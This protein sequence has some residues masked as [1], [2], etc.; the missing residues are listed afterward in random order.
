MSNRSAPKAER[1]SSSNLSAELTRTITEAVLSELAE[2]GYGQLSMDGVARRAKAGKSALYRRWPS[3]QE[4][5]LDAVSGVS[6]P[7]IAVDAS[8]DL[9]TVV[10]SAVEAVD[11]WLTSGM[12][13]RIVP[14][15][16]AEALRNP[17]LDTALTERIGVMRRRYWREVFEQ[18]IETEEVSAGA[19]I[20]Y[21]L[22]LLAAPLFWRACGRRR[23]SDKAL[24]Q[25]VIQSI[26]VVLHPAT[27]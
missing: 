10:T 25:N 17:A 19:D 5:I 4:M 2:V 16:I 14:D 11:S 8:Q 7:E 24:K 6:V 13:R 18:R 15:L 22:D 21:A 1:P 20:E 26:M 23:E 3:K 9:R 12:N 27:R